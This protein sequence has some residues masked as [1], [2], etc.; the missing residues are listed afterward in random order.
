MPRQRPVFVLEQHER[1]GVRLSR[2][3]EHRR[4]DGHGPQPARRRRLTQ[5]ELDDL[6]APQTRGHQ[7][8]VESIAEFSR[9]GVA[10]VGGARRASDAGRGDH[11]PVAEGRGF[12]AQSVFSHTIRRLSERVGEGEI[13]AGLV[14]RPASAP[15]CDADYNSLRYS[16]AR[17][18]Q[19]PGTD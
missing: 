3:L 12:D 7:Q 1:A 14:G 2:N 5:I 8:C 19:A 6:V 16:R 18:T 13:S 17:P 10:I 15:R 11:V 9:Y 4:I